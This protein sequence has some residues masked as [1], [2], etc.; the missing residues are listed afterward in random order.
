MAVADQTGW[1]A[2]ELATPC[3]AVVYEDWQEMLQRARLDAV[4][5]LTP[6]GAHAEQVIAAVQRGLAV[7]VE[8]PLALTM[9]DAWRMCQAV[10]EA[11][12][13]TCVGYCWRYS[14]GILKAREI[15]GERPLALT[16]A[17]YLWT[18]PPV[19]WI[20][21]KE[22]GGGQIV[23]QMTHLIDL[24]QLFGGPI[25]EVYAAYTLN[26]YTDEEFHN[27]DGY[28]LSWKHASGAVGSGHSTYALFPEIE[29]FAES[30]VDLA[31][32]NLFLRA[33]P[34]GLTVV[35]PEGTETYPNSGVFHAGVNRA[36]IS[37]LLTGDH[38]YVTSSIP[39]TFRSFA[40]TLAA[41]EAARTGKPVNLDAF[42]AAARPL[43]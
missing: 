39:R 17:E 27:W 5:V 40:V 28:A 33:T 30:K 11:G 20:R 32:R 4:Y 36:F 6:T 12:V 1:R 34:S 10:E 22:L 37:A 35:T 8:K 19:L 31:A 29:K 3:G 21:N 7:F 15:L 25:T 26:T 13:L 18:L 41:G 16:S 9:A 43:H 14:Q 38:S 42:I 24:C 23:D 2:K